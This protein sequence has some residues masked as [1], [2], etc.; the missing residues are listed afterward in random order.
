MAPEI[1]TLIN[2]KR[3]QAAD[4]VVM[5]PVRMYHGEEMYAAVVESRRSLTKWMP[6]VAGVKG[7]S[8]TRNFIRHSLDQQAEGTGIQLGIWAD[9]AFAGHIGLHDIDW[10]N[11]RT[12]IGYWLAERARGR[13]VMTACARAL[14]DFALC[15]LPLNRVEIRC[16]VENAPSRAIPERLGYVEEGTAREDMLVG[17][18]YVDLVV[19]AALARQWRCGG[20][21][22]EPA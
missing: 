15:E 13:G 11:G 19:Y 7:V 3:L 22:G 16:A 14:T 21:S 6:W 8:D 12:S 1:D 17:G 2:L 10:V 4:G 9:A 18:R 5:R 20:A